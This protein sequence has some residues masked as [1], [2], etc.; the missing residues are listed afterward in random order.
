MAQV[1]TKINPELN[2]VF[3]RIFPMTKNGTIAYSSA[4]ANSTIKQAL[5][6]TIINKS[7][8]NIV[9]VSASLG[10]SM[11]KNVSNYCFMNK[12][13]DNNLK[14]SL[15]SLKSMGVGVAFAAG[16]NRNKQSLLKRKPNKENAIM[17]SFYSTSS[18]IKIE[19]TGLKIYRLMNR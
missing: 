2:I 9:A 16:N 4:N 17:L 15:S 14:S 12:R 5:D 13:T 8:F 10:H 7:K 1:A 3:I 19:H 11:T 18:R 6:W